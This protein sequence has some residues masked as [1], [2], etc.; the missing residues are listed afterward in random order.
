MTRVQNLD[1]VATGSAP[2]RHNDFMMQ[3][4]AMIELT[5]AKSICSDRLVDFEI[6][7]TDCQLT[8]SYFGSYSR[9]KLLNMASDSNIRRMFSELQTCNEN[10]Q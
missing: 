7:C 10:P 5:T 2:L 3:I 8:L 9:S 1:H 4:A 6:Q